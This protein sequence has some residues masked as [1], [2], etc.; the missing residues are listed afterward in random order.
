MPSNLMSLRW[1]KQSTSS[2]SWTSV[3]F[4]IDASVVTYQATGALQYSTSILTKS[5]TK[6][7]GEEVLRVFQWFIP[8]V[9]VLSS[10]GIAIILILRIAQ[11]NLLAGRATGLNSHRWERP[12]LHWGYFLRFPVYPTATKL[13]LVGQ[14]S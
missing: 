1:Y 3:A 12:Y 7:Q 5:A 4:A 13:S 6:V 11:L 2:I 14:I 9:F 8:R 10:L